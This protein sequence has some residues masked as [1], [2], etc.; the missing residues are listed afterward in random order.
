MVRC[1]VLFQCGNSIHISLYENRVWTFKWKHGHENAINL[2]VK[3]LAKLCEY[4]IIA[5]QYR[6]IYVHA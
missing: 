1:A 3:L 4:F 2:Q 6:H 5:V